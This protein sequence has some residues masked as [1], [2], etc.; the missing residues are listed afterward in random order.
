MD[1]VKS[2][3]IRSYSGPHFPHLDWIRENADQNKSKYG[4]F[5][6]SGGLTFLRK[7]A[8]LS[9]KS[10]LFTLFH[11][12]IFETNISKLK[13]KLILNMQSIR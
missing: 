10:I 4:H 3:R 7:N 9:K 1:C 6:C 11:K 13:K 8:I 12:V 2:V 5:L